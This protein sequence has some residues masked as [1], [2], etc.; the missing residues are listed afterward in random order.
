M[1]EKHKTKYHLSPILACNITFS[2]KIYFI[3]NVSEY[4]I[5]F[6]LKN[7]FIF[8]KLLIA[9]NFQDKIVMESQVECFFFFFLLT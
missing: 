3:A 6:S 2:C 5:T 7:D 8:I 1:Q 4:F 9:L